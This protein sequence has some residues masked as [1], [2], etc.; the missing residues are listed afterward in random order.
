MQR[1]R[2]DRHAFDRLDL[3]QLLEMLLGAPYVRLQAPVPALDDVPRPPLRPLL[4]LEVPVHDVPPTGSQSELDGGRVHHDPVP[5]GDAAG[6]L[7]EDVRALVPVT[8]VDL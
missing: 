3:S 2:Y 4:P 1:S 7:G 6:Q 8:E 5:H